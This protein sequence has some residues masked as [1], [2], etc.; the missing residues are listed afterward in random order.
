MEGWKKKRGTELCMV[1]NRS[2]LPLRILKTLC[3]NILFIGQAI[4]YLPQHS[5]LARSIAPRALRLSLSLMLRPTI[6][7]SVCLGIKDPSGAYE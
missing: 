5:L 2:C 6:S 4:R 3:L 1:C 7:R